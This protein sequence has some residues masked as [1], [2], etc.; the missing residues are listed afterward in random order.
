MDNNHFNPY[1]KR[2]LNKGIVVA[3]ERGK[4]SFV[5]SLFKEYILD[6]YYEE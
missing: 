5:L 6:N 4:L 1:R 2:L 3:K